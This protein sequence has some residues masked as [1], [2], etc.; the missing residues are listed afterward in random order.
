MR[1][2]ALT[3]QTVTGSA[4]GAVE[5]V[6]TP[7]RPL[8]HRAGQGG[9]L[10][11]P[12]GG[13]KP[14]TF[15]SDDRSGQLSVATTLSSGSRFKQALADLRPGDPA[16]AAGAIGSLP[17]L[18]AG[19]HQVFVAQG[20]GITPFL[21]MARSYDRLD[22]TLLQVG[23]PHFFDEV[24]AATTAAEHHDH[25]EGLAD[26]VARVVADRPDARWSLSGRS[27][28]VSALAVQLAEAG[29]PARRVHKDAFWGMRAPAATVTAHPV[30][31]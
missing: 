31:A 19:E 27:G 8:S 13:V 26:A 2:T 22:A 9:L 7:I 24:A 6:F 15:S 4:T 21:A 16:F 14:F 11:V 10:R 29:V 3:L 1:I 28:F 5:L 20:I 23:T 30:N 18:D 25:R 12:G 17:A